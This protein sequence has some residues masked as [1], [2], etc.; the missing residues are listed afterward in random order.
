MQVTDNIG[1]YNKVMT[2]IVVNSDAST[3]PYKLNRVQVFIPE[4][5]SGGDLYDLYQKIQES[6]STEHTNK[7][8]WAYNTVSDLKNGDIIYITNLSNAIGSYVVIGRDV[9]SSSSGGVGGGDDMDAGNIVELLLPLIIHEECGAGSPPLYLYN[10]KWPD[11][12]PDSAYGCYTAKTS[13]SFSV[14]LLNWDASRAYELL[15]DVAQ[16]D[17]NWESYWEDKSYIAF[18]YIKEDARTGNTTNKSHI[19]SCR[20]SDPNIIKS[21]QKMLTSK[22]GKEWQLAKARQEMTDLIQTFQEKQG[23]TNPAVMIFLGD[24]CNQWTYKSVDAS[25]WESSTYRT[26]Y[27][28]AQS[29]LKQGVDTGSIDKA[30]TSYENPSEMMKELEALY[31]WYTTVAVKTCCTDGGQYGDVGYV[32]RRTRALSYIRE[33]YKQGKLTCA[34]M[35]MLGNLQQATYNGLTLAWPFEDTI[36]NGTIVVTDKYSA[37]TK[38]PAKYHLTSLFGLRGTSSGKHSGVDFGCP[39]GVEYYAVHDGMC[40]VEDSGSDSYKVNGQWVF[41]GGYGYCVKIEFEQNGDNWLVIYGHCLRGSAAQYNITKNKRQ[42]RAGEKIAQANSTGSSTGNH[43]HF[44]LRRNGK[45]INP[46]PYLGL[47]DAHYPLPSGGQYIAD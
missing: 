46:L 19:Q 6:G 30:M 21:I 32:R 22:V 7:F 12:I 16:K 14:G 45:Y 36:Q 5:Q 47:G 24:F 31:L 11:N 42:V 26:V 9:V 23:I 28:A 35:T 2:A 40:W 44:E 13:S 43:L 3:D 4:I 20:T 38:T 37:T 18:Q 34:G 29:P 25:H 33:L 17:G 8:S 1:Y 15:I 27:A 10:D 41:R 39:R